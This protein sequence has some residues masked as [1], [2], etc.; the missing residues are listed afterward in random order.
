LKRLL[1]LSFAFFAVTGVCYGQAGFIGLYSDSPGYSN[2]VLIDGDQGIVTVYVVH[3]GTPGATMSWFKGEVGGGFGCTPVG[4]GHYFTTSGP[5]W[6]DAGIGLFYEACLASDILLITL[7][8]SCTGTSANCA[9]IRV[10][11][12]PN[13]RSGEIEVVDCDRN[14]L[15]GGGSIMYI[16]PDGSC[17]CGA[18]PVENSTWGSIKS[19]YR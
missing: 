1:L 14:R 19:L 2:C 9:W 16:N 3:K 5:G 12:D 8:F 18:V 11:G 4:E 6:F 10:V 7:E 15:V 13:H 17:H